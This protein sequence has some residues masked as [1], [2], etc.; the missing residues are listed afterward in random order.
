MAI[1]RSVASLKL[2]RVSFFQV[3]FKAQLRRPSSRRIQDVYTFETV[4]HA[5]MLIFGIKKCFVISIIQVRN[6]HV[7]SNRYM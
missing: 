4:P 1:C 7:D 6:A 2:G 5:T 3:R